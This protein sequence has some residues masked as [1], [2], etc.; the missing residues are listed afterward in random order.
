L[1]LKR[2]KV[3]TLKSPAAIIASPRHS[4]HGRFGEGSLCDLP[5]IAHSGVL[6][7]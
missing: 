3:A 6:T 5:P 7:R 1:R 4:P 2:L